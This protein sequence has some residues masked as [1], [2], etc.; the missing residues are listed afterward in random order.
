MRDFSSV[1][2]A[3]FFVGASDLGSNP[4]Q[5][6]MFSL[7]CDRLLVLVE[8]PSSAEA[9]AKHKTMQTTTNELLIFLKSC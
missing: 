2:F 4:D 1:I 3:L 7:L 9:Q 5:K 6:A 8:G